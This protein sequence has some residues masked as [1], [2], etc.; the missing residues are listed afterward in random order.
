MESFLL[1][2][3]ISL[4]ILYTLYHWVIRHGSNHQLN[5]FIG[6]ACILFSCS[7]IFIPINNS[8]ISGDFLTIEI[9][10]LQESL[11]F[12]EGIS[13]ITS[14][15]SISIY[16]IIYIAG[17]I[18]FSSRFLIG[19]FTL[20]NFYFKSNK[21]AR[22]GFQVVTVH[23]KLSPFTF[24]NILF[25]GNHNMKDDELDALIIHEQFHRDQFHSIDVL[26]LEILTIVYW[27]NP[28]IWLFRKRIKAEHEYM[29]DKQVLKK[30]YNQLDYQQLLFQVR[31][32]ASLQIG[33]Y[34]SNNISLKKRF[35]MMAKNKVNKKSRYLKAILF[36]PL[37]F[38]ILIFSS[39]LETSDNVKPVKLREQD[40]RDENKLK[41][42]I[43][44]SINDNKPFIKLTRNGP[45]DIGILPLYVLKDGY[46]ER[47]V[48]YAFFK[49]L[50]QSDIGNINIIKGDKAA[51]KYGENG[52]NGVVVFDLKK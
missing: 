51:E 48:S 2:S 24:F 43:T 6:F 41:G 44:F 23:K 38:L 4:I 1:K 34:L 11:N 12:K 30:G 33:S 45:E 25:I 32:G 39:F 20:I 3:S 27:F 19:I 46:D 42:D 14:K 28:A 17:V 40:T 47:I 50:N 22:W 18:L 35:K 29:A 7:F 9:K 13:T 16:L 8:L 10:A 26:I 21:Y 52:E 5:R 36:L 15:N 31:T 37:M 49:N